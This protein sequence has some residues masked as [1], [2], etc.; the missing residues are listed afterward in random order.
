MYLLSKVLRM[1][2]SLISE[3]TT[4]LHFSRLVPRAF[5]FF[6]GFHCQQLSTNFLKTFFKNME[7]KIHIESECPVN[8]TDL[9][10]SLENVKCIGDLKM[11]LQPLLSVAACDM[12]VFYT[13]QTSNKALE[14]TVE[15]S[16]LY[17]Q[18]QDTFVVKFEST[19]EMHFL[20]GFIN[21]MKA[22]VTNIC[23]VFSQGEKISMDNADWENDEKL[24]EYDEFYLSVILDLQYCSS[25]TFV[26]WTHKPTNAN[27]HYF[28]QEDGLK[29]L[30]RIYRF[31]SRSH[32]ES[33]GVTDEGRPD[34]FNEK[35]E[36]LEIFCLYTLWNFSEMKADR[37]LVLKVIGLEP[38]LY[39][40][41]KD[42]SSVKDLEKKSR[43]NQINDS[44][45][46]CLV[47]YVELPNIQLI[48]AEKKEVLSKLFQIT[49]KG[50]NAYQ[51]EVAANTLFCC[52]SH[53]RA[54]EKI[55]ENKCYEMVLK[56]VEATED[57]NALANLSSA[58]AYFLCLYLANILTLPDKNII[59]QEET[60]RIN[61]VLETFL[62][63]CRPV[64]IS[65]FQETHN[66]VWITLI[67]F[68]QLALSGPRKS[69]QTSINVDAQSI[70][71]S[72]K[73]PYKFSPAEKIGLF[74]LCHLVT[75]EENR[76]LFRKEQIV[77]YL[78]CA[79]W[80][81]KQCP[82]VNDLIPKLEDFHQREP[83]RL[84]S[85]AK[86][87]LSKCFGHNIMY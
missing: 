40:L 72:H 44:S 2:I 67:P 59:T 76:K 21:R 50:S 24:R 81:A 29:L 73:S 41:L 87:Y 45:V 6:L 20:S 39:S 62:Q 19:C 63:I 38:F 47:Q 70:K 51:K 64:T 16:N 71:D 52:S 13:R 56:T 12:S 46:G 15:I 53:P 33:V 7:V 74:C 83:P 30:G 36:E 68:L 69:C 60:E 84:E 5:P 49:M 8:I 26:P 75:T 4:I 61:H 17:V 22:F 85:I 25:S 43:L 14:N 65:S 79:Q 34:Y 54:A 48:I 11:K 37:Q 77:D 66:Y 3:Q 86:A 1:R 55:I 28:A 35:Q 9:K 23:D 58:V 57:R 80:F 78:I 32:F 31:A 10:I 42:E 82:D 27:R 18:E